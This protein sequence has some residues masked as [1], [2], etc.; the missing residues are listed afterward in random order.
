MSTFSLMRS[1][2]SLSLSGTWT[3]NV[4]LDANMR[5]NLIQIFDGKSLILLES[6]TIPLKK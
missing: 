1:P 4:L 5:A 3:T 6:S 2:Q